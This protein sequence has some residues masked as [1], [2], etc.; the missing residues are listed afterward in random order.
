MLGLFRKPQKRVV[1]VKRDRMSVTADEWRSSHELC[2]LAR[3]VLADPDM[4]LMLDCIRNSH[5][6]NYALPDSATI[7]ERAV[8]Q[9]EIQG[10]N[11]ALRMLT[12]LQEPKQIDKPIEADFAPE[13]LLQNQE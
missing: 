1:I 11:L 5:V 6:A 13:I 9:A 2:A 12:L 4:R 10:F 8:H 7:D 3:R